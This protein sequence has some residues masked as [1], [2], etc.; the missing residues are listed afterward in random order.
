VSINDSWYAS[1]LQV[2]LLQSHSNC[3]GNGTT[4]MENISR[5]EP[6]PFLFGVPSDYT[7]IE[8]EWSHGV[9]F[10]SPHLPPMPPFEF[11]QL[12]PL[13]RSSLALLQ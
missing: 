5:N 3:F 8:Q 10:V 1:E 7:I 13:Q 11:P 2:I 9:N 12:P 6:D 4:R